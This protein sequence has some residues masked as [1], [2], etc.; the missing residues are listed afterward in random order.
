MKKLTRREKGFVLILIA[1]L[2]EAIPWVLSSVFNTSLLNPDQAPRFPMLAYGLVMVMSWGK[3]FVL[4][5]GLVLVFSKQKVSET[6]AAQSTL[7]PSETSLTPVLKKHVPVVLVLLVIE[8]ALFL[9][10]LAMTSRDWQGKDAL[11]VILIPMFFINQLLGVAG[12]IVAVRSVA[13]KQRIVA[14]IILFLLSLLFASGMVFS[15]TT[16]ISRQLTGEARQEKEQMMIHEQELQKFDEEQ[17]EWQKTNEDIDTIAREF[18]KRY[19]KYFAGTK[20]YTEFRYGS[21][22]NDEDKLYPIIYG[23]PMEDMACPKCYVEIIDGRKVYT[24]R[25]KEAKRYEVQ[26][27][28]LAP[29]IGK[30]VQVVVAPY[31]EV[32]EAMR[33]GVRDLLQDAGFFVPD[34]ER[35]G[36]QMRNPERPIEYYFDPIALFPEYG[37]GVQA[38]IYYQGRNINEEL[39]KAT[40]EF[41]ATYTE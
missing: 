19:Q 29:L 39:K 8:V 41:E 1:I 32:K 34:P 24:G 21:L 20:I 16:W 30:P 25:I 6:P 9:G 4:V 5:Y 11:L 37:Y 7:S 3:I 31:E 12:I 2:I 15:S 35:P 13:R 36:F 26:K 38:I 23:V 40:E 10:L 18:H 28:I 14:S 33:L 17:A 22:G 27:E